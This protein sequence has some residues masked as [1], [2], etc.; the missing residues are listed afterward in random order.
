MSVALE[1]M[2]RLLRIKSNR[3]EWSGD[4]PLGIEMLFAAG[5]WTASQIIEW[6]EDAAR[7]AASPAEAA[8]CI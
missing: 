7:A 2:T 1:S 5:L 3:G 8:P 4:V 6:G